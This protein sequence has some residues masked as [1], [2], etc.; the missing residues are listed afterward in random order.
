[1]KSDRELVYL[2][3]EEMAKLDRIAIDEFGLD[4][5][6][7]MENA[8]TAVARLVRVM[9]GGSVAQRS[10]CCLVGK[11]NNGGDGLVAARHLCNWG[12]RTTV[13]QAG[14][15]NE[16][17]DVPARQFATVERMGIGIGGSDSDFGKPDLIVDALLGYSSKGSPRGPVRDL[18]LRANESKSAI[19]AVDL[20]SGLDATSGE[21]N[22]PCIRAGATITFGLPKTGF[23]NPS[24]RSLIGE[25][26]LAD[27]SLPAELY[28]R[29]GQKSGL[30]QKDTI[31]KVS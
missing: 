22:D 18:V 30:F 19:V 4:V 23:L 14:E 28:A 7:L 24:A 29:F 13:I 15:K 5:L 16:L 25:L 21:P 3:G 8:G 12:A 2:T 26:Y 11:G 27:I 9:L 31:L 1:M 6:I 20:P 10:V 17:R